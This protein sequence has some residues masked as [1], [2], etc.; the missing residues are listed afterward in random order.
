MPPSHSGLA[1]LIALFTKQYGIYSTIDNTLKDVKELGKQEILKFKCEFCDA[2]FASKVGLEHHQREWCGEPT[3]EVF[4]EEYE[5]DQIVEARG[6][7]DRRFYLTEWVGY[8]KDETNWEPARHFDGD[9][10]PVHE[11]W[12]AHP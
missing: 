5:V 8:S 1:A 3:R 9:L 11:F 4:E 12:K 2:V 10:N 6:L 7:P